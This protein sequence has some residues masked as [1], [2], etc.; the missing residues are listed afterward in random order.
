MVGCIDVDVSGGWSSGLFSLCYNKHKAI[1][2]YNA[3]RCSIRMTH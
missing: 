3:F 1:F 2:I